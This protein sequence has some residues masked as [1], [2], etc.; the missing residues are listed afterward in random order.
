MCDLR[1]YYIV[2]NDLT[3]SELKFDDELLTEFFDFQAKVNLSDK[4]H[5]Q[6]ILYQFNSSGIPGGPIQ[7]MANLRL[8]CSLDNNKHNLIT[9]LVKTII[10]SGGTQIKPQDIINLFFNKKQLISYSTNTLPYE[11]ICK[12]VEPSTAIV[13]TYLNNQF[14]L[15]LY[16]NLDALSLKN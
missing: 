13:T 16:S 4:I 9:N 7:Y 1:D 6:M 5:G 3:F 10:I 11:G 8:V 2:F 12:E 15:Y 14:Y